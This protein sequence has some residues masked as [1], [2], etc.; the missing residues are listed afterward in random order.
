MQ[1][2]GRRRWQWNQRTII[3]RKLNEYM[4]HEFSSYLLIFAL[5]LAEQRQVVELFGH[6]RMILTQHLQGNKQQIRANAHET[7][8]SI[9]LISYAGRL[10]LSSVISAK[11]HSLSM[12]RSLKSR[13]I[14][15]KTPVFGVQGRSRSSMLVPLESSSTVL[16]MISSKSVS[17]CNRSRAGC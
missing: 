8:D 4:T 14:S 7:R 9:G 13:K 17:I 11:I 6:V 10:G 15:L 1:L 3:M 12:R 16:A 5:I 2:A